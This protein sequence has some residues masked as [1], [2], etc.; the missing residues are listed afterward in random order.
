MNRQRVNP[1]EL[2]NDVLEDLKP[3][4][5]G[6]QIDLRIGQL[7]SCQADPALLKQ[8]WV[9]LLSNAIK[10]SCG[11]ELAIVEIGCTFTGKERRHLFCARQWDRI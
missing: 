4:R 5:Q 7:P 3:Q 1:L 6:R 2:V 11:R 9:N 8:V 10:Y